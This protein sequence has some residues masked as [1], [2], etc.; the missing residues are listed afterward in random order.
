MI[1]VFWIM[2]ACSLAGAY[3]RFVGP[4]C[5]YLLSHIQKT[6]RSSISQP[7]IPEM[8]VLNLSYPHFTKFS[9]VIRTLEPDAT[10]SYETLVKIYQITRRHVSE[11][12][13]HISPQMS[14]SVTEAAE[15]EALGT[16]IHNRGCQSEHRCAM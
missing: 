3:R 14:H 13:L 4:G 7:S 15:V 16:R 1:L 6:T 5:L 11:N 12:S 2:A 9:S 8:Y 10:R